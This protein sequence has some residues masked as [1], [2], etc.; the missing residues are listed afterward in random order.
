MT[1]PVVEKFDRELQR[2]LLNILFNTY[3]EP[4]C[5]SSYYQANY[6]SKH[7]L[8]YVALPEPEEHIASVLAKYEK[9][10]IAINLNYLLE[11]GVIYPSDRIRM[12]PVR[13]LEFKITA[14]GI[15]NILSD[16]GLS[17]L[18]NVVTIKFA[19]DEM[20]KLVDVIKNSNVD[21]A[22]KSYLLDTLKKIPAESLTQCLT[23]MTVQA[24]GKMPDAVQWLE[25]YLRSCHR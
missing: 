12:D 10:S 16:G 6:S 17:A 15:D 4:V 14:K 22:K 2:E 7:Q 5:F 21:E 20:A 24:L 23:S 1:D 18:F 8:G 13:L 9:E 25:T 19:D 11:H 3:P